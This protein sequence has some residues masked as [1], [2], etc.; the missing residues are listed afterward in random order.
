MSKAKLTAREW[1]AKPGR[2]AEEGA[3]RLKTR[4]AVEQA[5]KTNM[6]PVSL[7]DEDASSDDQSEAEQVRHSNTGARSSQD[8]TAK[9]QEQMSLM[10][11]SDGEGEEDF[12]GAA[13]C[14]RQS[15]Y[16]KRCGLC[17]YQHYRTSHFGYIREKRP[18]EG[19]DEITARHM[20]AKTRDGTGTHNW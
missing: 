6:H 19:P 2:D 14:T 10:K 15:S 11:I 18:G 7:S 17:S 4:A 8:N 20:R 1:L 12:A 3:L 13:G 16:L 9:V 5:Q